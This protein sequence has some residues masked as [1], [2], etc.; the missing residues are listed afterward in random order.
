MLE[1]SRALRLSGVGQW[2]GRSL[3]ATAA[4][5]F[6]RGFYRGYAEALVYLSPLLNL[7]GASVSN[8]ARKR[9]H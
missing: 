6:S 9:K 4:A 7:S 1:V 5:G 3:R 8:A 2:R